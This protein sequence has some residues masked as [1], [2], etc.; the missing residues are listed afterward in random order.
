MEI[1]QKIKLYINEAGFKQ[2]RIAEKAGYDEKKFSAMMT[3]K[4]KVYADDLERICRALDTP[5]TTFID[6]NDKQASEKT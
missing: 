3:G 4:R 1:Y 6:Y 5:P 2:G